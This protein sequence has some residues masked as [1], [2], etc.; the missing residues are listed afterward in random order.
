MTLRKIVHRVLDSGLPGALSAVAAMF[1]FVLMGMGSRNR[2][3]RASRRP[4]RSLRRRRATTRPSARTLQ[5]P[6]RRER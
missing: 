2:P 6:P 1:G 3:S 4:A 5:L